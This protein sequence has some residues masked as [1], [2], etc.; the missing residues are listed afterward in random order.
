MI[1][2]NLEFEFKIGYS[3]EWEQS[4]F[5]STSTFQS[6]SFTAGANDTVILKRTPV[7]AYKYDLWD[8]KNNTWIKDGHS[9]QVAKEALYY[10]LTIDEYNAS[11]IRKTFY[12]HHLQK[13]CL[14]CLK[15]LA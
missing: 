9:V 13:L 10:T 6:V 3:G 15:V 5:N 4:T 11:L 1:K 7:Y 8:A 2:S 14:L 12:F